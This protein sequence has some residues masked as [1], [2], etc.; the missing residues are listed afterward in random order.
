MNY[1]VIML[2]DGNYMTSDGFFKMEPNTNSYSLSTAIFYNPNTD[3]VQSRIVMD[4]DDDRN[5]ELYKEIYNMP[6]CKDEQV[7]A[8]Y[9]KAQRK[10]KHKIG[11]FMVGDL[12]KIVKGR[13]LPIGDIKQ[14]KSFYDWQD[15]F[16]RVQARYVIFTDDTKTNKE[17]CSLYKGILD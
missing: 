3:I 2:S 8:Y 5:Y 1:K 12:V 4:S 7:I 11:M 15:R 6:Y 13:K 10:L 14:I 17:N 16:G 9:E